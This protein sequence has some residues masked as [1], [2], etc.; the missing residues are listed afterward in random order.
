[1]ANGASRA[2]AWRDLPQANQ[3]GLIINEL[4]EF[5]ARQKT[6]V[7]SIDIR[8]GK[9]ERRSQFILATFVALL[10]ALLGNVVVLVLATT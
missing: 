5:D 8:L 9:I 6:L 10:L 1:M 4:D 3:I 7:E 2:V